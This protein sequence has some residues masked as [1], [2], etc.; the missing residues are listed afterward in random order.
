MR[1][2]REGALIQKRIFFFKPVYSGTGSIFKTKM[3][4]SL[5]FLHLRMI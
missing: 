2:V 4:S 5:P 3:A 1:E